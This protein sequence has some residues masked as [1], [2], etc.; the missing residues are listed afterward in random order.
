MLLRVQQSLACDRS[1][2]NAACRL[3]VLFESFSIDIFERIHVKESFEPTLGHRILHL[4]RE[5]FGRVAEA[6][7]LLPGSSI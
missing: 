3:D 1:T 7:M 2:Y 6:R 5:V 4:H